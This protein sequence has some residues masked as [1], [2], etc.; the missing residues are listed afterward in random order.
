[1]SEDTAMPIT[2]ALEAKLGEVDVSETTHWLRWRVGRGGGRTI[3]AQIAAEASDDDVLIGVMDTRRLAEEAVT[4]HNA[5]LTRVQ[6]PDFL[7]EPRP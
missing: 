4:A 2:D 7:S 3:Y 1:M 5:V 6:H